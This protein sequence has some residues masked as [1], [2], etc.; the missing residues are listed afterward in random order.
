MGG[1]VPDGSRS[2]GGL[3]I[4]RGERRGLVSSVLGS[5]AGGIVGVRREWIWAGGAIP[6]LLC[7]CAST[8]IMD[9]SGK[10]MSMEAEKV[11]D[12]SLLVLLAMAD[13]ES[14]PRLEPA[15]PAGEAAARMPLVPHRRLESNMATSPRPRPFISTH[16]PDPDCR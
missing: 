5:A 12:S 8:A 13:K 11:H 14:T 7:Q 10:A 2:L 6:L 1:L 16:C 9:S 15:P 3:G 4:F